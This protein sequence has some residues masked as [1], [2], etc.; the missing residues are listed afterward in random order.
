VTVV[1]YSSA[2]CHPADDFPEPD[3]NTRRCFPIYWSP[4]GGPERQLDWFHKYV[5][6]DVYSADTTGGSPTI[7]TSYTYADDTGAAKAAWHHADDAVSPTKWRTWSQWR[8][9]SRVTTTVGDAQGEPRS[10]TVSVYL[11]G[12]DGDKQSG[13]STRKASVTGTDLPAG[14]DKA[15]APAITDSDP[16]AGFLREQITYDGNTPVSGTWYE[17]WSSQTAS[18]TYT[19][20]DYTAKATYVR[21]AAEHDWTTITSASGALSPRLRTTST[22]Y[23]KTY[24][25][26]TSV[27]DSGDEAKTDDQTCQLTTYARNPQLGLTSLVSRSQVL[28]TTCDAASVSAAKLPSDYTTTGD[29][30]SDSATVYDTAAT[31]WVQDQKPTRGDATW[32]GRASGYAS[33]RTATWQ[34]VTATTYDALGRPLTVSNAKNKTTTTEYTPAQAEPLTSTTVVNALK[35]GTTTDLDP[36]WQLPIKTIAWQSPVTLTTGWRAALDDADGYAEITEVTYDALGRLTKVW[37]PT[38]PRRVGTATSD[39]PPNIKFAYQV[40]NTQASWVSTSK[41]RQDGVSYGTSY[42]IYDAV[43]RQRQ[44]Q[45]PSA[46]AGTGRVITTTI[47]DERGLKYGT[48][49]GIFNQDS[50]PSGTLV[51]LAEDQ[52]APAQ[53]RTTFDGAARPKT[54]EFST[55]NTPRWSTTTEYTG[56]SVATSAPEGG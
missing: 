36:A 1:S 24:G 51:D 8:G 12:M 50:A 48:D 7:H 13:S 28:A 3:E 42:A 17:P 22:A 19:G 10:T 31:T 55:K 33:D 45:A 11:Q 32:T 56:D 35:H 23:D 20:A 37:L 6:T 46:T 2:Q 4:L 39:S 29:V 16:L 21:T 54:T 52:R 18:Y 38:H 5:V 25:M 47:F 43:L 30:I 34:K 53:T 27:E 26:A 14:L 49:S 44:I 9:Y 40:S 15:Q 41:I